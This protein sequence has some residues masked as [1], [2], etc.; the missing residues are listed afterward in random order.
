MPKHTQVYIR[1][2]LVKLLVVNSISL[3]IPV[4]LLEQNMLLA[5]Y[6]DI[7]FQVTLQ[8]IYIYIDICLHHIFL[9]HIILSIQNQIIMMRPIISQYIIRSPLI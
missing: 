2:S 1:K 9:Y 4:C 5:I 8:L 6:F 3:S 7:S